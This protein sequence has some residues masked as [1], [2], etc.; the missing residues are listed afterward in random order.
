M[1]SVKLA[2]ESMK[3]GWENMS[4]L[5]KKWLKQ[6]KMQSVGL[7]G[8][9]MSKLQKKWLKTNQNAKYGIGGRKYDCNLQFAI[10]VPWS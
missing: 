4:K 2:G 8:K 9:N 5:L 6:T 1:Q 10:M 3:V 7:A